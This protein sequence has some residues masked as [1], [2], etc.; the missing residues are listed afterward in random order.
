M[1]YSERSEE[2]SA[3]KE[4][5]KKTIVT[6]VHCKK[7]VVNVAKCRKCLNS[8]HPACLDQAAEQKNVQC[9][10]EA[11]KVEKQVNA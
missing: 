6:F 4:S 7:R 5:E 10:H 2:E 3:F 8:F 11:V 9:S 1:A